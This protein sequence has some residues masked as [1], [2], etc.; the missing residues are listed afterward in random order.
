[1]TEQKTTEQTNKT[2]PV[3]PK[4]KDK[5]TWCRRILCGISAV[6][7]GFIFV[8]LLLLTTSRGQVALI[9]FS[10]KLLDSLTIG[11]VSGGLQEGLVLKNVHYHTEGIEFSLAQA[12][13][14]LDLHCLWQ[15]KICLQDLSL[16]QPQVNIDT[17]FLSSNETE[18]NE[19]STMQRIRLPISLQADNLA[20]E[21]LS[22]NIDQ[23]QIQLAQFKSAV[24]LNN[25]SGLTLAPT[26]ITQL[27]IHQQ[28][29][30]TTELDL[31]EA[32]AHTTTPIDWQQLEQRLQQ[33]L[34]TNLNQVQLPFDLHITNIEGTNW[35]Y[36]QTDGEQILQHITVS[37]LQLQA[38]AVNDKIQLTTLVI[39][40]SLGDINGSGQIQLQQDFPLDFHLSSTLNAIKHEQQVLLSETKLALHLTGNLLKQTQLSLTSQGGLNA[41]LTAQAELNQAKTPFQLQVDLPHWRY[42]ASGNDPLNTKDIHFMA[43]GNLLDYQLDFN[44]QAQG[45]GVPKSQLAMH[46]QGGLTQAQIQQFQLNTLGGSAEIN[47]E[48]DWHN[49]LAW[50]SDLT[51]KQINSAE[52]NLDWRALLSGQLSTTGY[53][54]A[55]DWQIAVNKLA[56]QGRINGQPLDLQGN[57]TA[58][59]TELIN[60]PQFVLNYGKNNL[61]LQG[62][63]NQQSDLKLDI[64]APN[65]TG[66]LPNLS[67]NLMGYINIKGDINE[68]NVDIDLTGKNIRFQ[69]LS[70]ADIKLTSHI[71]SQQQI[72]G[73]VDLNLRQFQFD[74]FKLNSAQLRLS[75]N[76]QQH[77]LQLRSQGQPVAANLDLNGHFSRAEQ[78]WQGDLTNLNI[79]SPIGQ[80]SNNKAITISYNHTDLLASVSAHCWDN[81]NLEL[82]FT[83]PLS[84]GENGEVHFTIPR[85]NLAIVNQ[86][87]EQANLLKGQLT[88]QGQVSWFADKPLDLTL[89]VEGKNLAVN[90]KIDYRSFELAISQLSLATSLKENNLAVKSEVQLANN[91]RLNTN[92]Q[93][94]DIAKQRQL[95]GSLA[96]NHLNLALF[97][98]LLTRGDSIKGEVNANL[99]FSGDLQSPLLNG[100]I[101]LEQLKLSM[102]ALPVPINN[103]QLAIQFNGNSS[104]LQG[105]I[106]N[107]NNDRLTL[108][109]SASWRDLE[110]WTA[111]VSAKAN[112]FEIDIPNMARLRISPDIQVSATPKLLNLSG[113]INIPWARMSIEQLPESAVSVSSDEVILDQTPTAQ[114]RIPRQ[115]EQPTGMLIQSDLKIHIGDNVH[116]DAY[117]L[118]TGLQGVLS[119]R[120][121]K[122]NLGLYGQINLQNGRYSSF[123][124]DLLIRKGQISFSGLPSQP[125]LN[126][127]AIRNPDVMEDTNVTAGVKVV[128]L[129]DSPE[130]TIFSEPSMSQAQ[131]LSYLLTGRSLEDSGDAGSGNS[132]GAALL[133][134]GLAKS[135]K[136]IGGIGEAFGIQELN[137]GTQGIGDSSQVV[138]S[139]YITPRL[140]VKYGV[141]LFNGLAEFTVKYRLM[142]RLYLQSVSGVNQAFDILYQF[143]F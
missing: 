127:E 24:S 115:V 31:T 139:G 76:E 132:V 106:E 70:I 99:H 45:M 49:G 107:Q 53:A 95:G 50:Q 80:V 89:Q 12:R 125:L 16:N 117:G 1:M 26:E 58:N 43:Q 17:A 48:V 30:P 73:N 14:Q 110:R 101:Q 36:Q 35:S 27:Q 3:A 62:H 40:S 6:I 69:Q 81:P 65:L 55:E 119:V 93:I 135:S 94:N 123:G 87:T 74:Q 111:E 109:G 64:N 143:E 83:Q 129:A 19:D 8:L 131:A 133:G 46:L 13:L 112:E 116:L 103:G 61:H 37:N 92:L 122:G 60:I 9:K 138:V 79:H 41:E 113:E 104:T 10:D 15:R 57:F 77:Q 71:T 78:I 97:D 100:N 63:L 54:N 85:L 34:L 72:Q 39:N 23:Q 82:C 25:E 142:P 20:I 11:D 75:G 102:I 67:A 114:I 124:Q 136:L 33:P 32:H 141:G 44:G 22:L 134:L 91:G 56:L 28:V 98:Q 4:N 38:E 68:P 137:L 140:Q 18:N 29:A 84:L 121:E 66:L 88:S 2:A 108:T 52:L 120:Q 42:P 21:R 90:Q 128:G 118:K 86:L 51:L 7:I 96:L 105:M 47:G 130:V 5:K 126:I 59:K